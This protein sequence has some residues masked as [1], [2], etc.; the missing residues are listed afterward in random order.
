MAEDKESVTYN[1]AFEI[2][3]GLVEGVD[4]DGQFRL[5]QALG[6]REI[7]LAIPSGCAQRLAGLHELE[8]TMSA[9][10]KRK[11]REAAGKCIRTT[12]LRRTC[13]ASKGSLGFGAAMVAGGSR[14][15]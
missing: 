1:I 8:K 14:K 12:S 3:E 11:K 5:R 15:R 2:V 6:Q 7:S 10:V 13:S 4:C 9:T